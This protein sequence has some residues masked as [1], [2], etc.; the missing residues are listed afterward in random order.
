MTIGYV[1]TN[2]YLSLSTP[3]GAD[4]LLLRAF[5]GEESLSTPFH[6][7]LDM[8]SEA[9]D[10]D[11]SQ[12][13]GKSVTIT[14]TASGGTRYVNG[15]MTRFVQAGTS[16]RFTAYFGEVRP[17][18]WMLNLAS[19][20]RIYQAQSALDIIKALFGELGYTDFRDATTGTYTARDY[21]V[22]Y[23]ETAFD[24]VSRLLEEEGIHYFFEHADGKHTMVLAD[25][26]DA[27]TALA[28]PT[29]VKFAKSG[30]DRSTDDRIV[31][32][33]YE[34]QV[35]PHTYALDDF[36]FTTPA[37]DLA[38]S[39]DGSDTGTLKRYDYPGGYATKDRG[40]ALAKLRI[41]SHEADEKV[42]RG[43]STVRT[44]LPGY[45][46]ALTDHPRTS[47]NATYLLRTVAHL[48]TAD[49]YSNRFEAIPSTVAFRPR[50]VTPKP[51]I[52][53]SQTAVVVGKA[54][55]EIWTDS[56][57]RVKVQFPWDQKG[58]NDE[59][60]SCWIRVAQ[61]WAGKSW[62]TLFTPRIGAE[63]VVSF[64]DG[65]PD[66]P[67]ITGTV[68]NATQT[69]PYTL[70][71]DQTKSTIKTMSSKTGTAGNEIRFEDKKDSE[72]LYFHAQKDM[73]TLIENDRT[74]TVTNADTLTV[75]KANK[76]VTV[77]EG[78]ES[79]TVTKG[80]RTVTVTAGDETHK[81]GGKRDLTVTGDETH[82]NS[83]K[84]THTVTGD[85]TLKVSGNLTIE[86]EGTISIKSGTTFA[87]EAGTA[88]TNKAGSDL[89]NQA[90]KGLTNKGATV[91][92][93]ADTTLTNKGATV[94][95]DA[96][97]Q[98]N[99]KSG[100]MQNVEAGGVLT[101]KGSVAKIN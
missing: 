40:E 97:T 51:R 87:N 65:D 83:G 88:M 48:A 27:H 12:L 79:L 41:E 86:S 39:V 4:N 6:F 50:C 45:T 37:T 100:G 56:Y 89:T 64:V 7:S 32:C 8:H 63:A 23:N 82:T 19:D 42:L 74:T 99:N 81:V 101:L 24:F 25:D 14:V 75:S 28:A 36:E 53:G 1:Q 55:E 11:F 44:F 2:T 35:I 13:V 34:Q 80:K 16:G 92:N 85:Y 94:T 96:S 95:N 67:L 3:L 98:L 43:D 59:N 61:G 15:L 57:G 17:W 9:S 68:Y 72:E 77:S 76:S 90:T 69:V 62:G 5:R 29:A 33:T 18:F 30:F 38:V 60:S 58:K 52:H 93:E 84:F 46:F 73:N 31:S 10:I 66:R 20:Q 49:E 91:S 21:C 70:P 26:A 54:G 71:A 22:Q 47:V 78:D